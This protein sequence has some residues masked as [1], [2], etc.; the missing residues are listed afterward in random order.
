MNTPRSSGTR[1][2]GIFEELAV[3]R[4]RAALPD[5]RSTAAWHSRM[6]HLKR[7]ITTLEKQGA[8]EETDHG[9]FQ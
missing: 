2:S 4:S 9:S 6:D 7:V 3:G 1:K 8:Y 5:A